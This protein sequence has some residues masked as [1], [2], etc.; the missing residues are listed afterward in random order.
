MN[1]SVYAMGESVR[2]KLEWTSSYSKLQVSV[3][4]KLLYSGKQVTALSKGGLQLTVGF[5]FPTTQ[6]LTQIESWAKLHVFLNAALT[7]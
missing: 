5:G 4:F 7:N 6:T 1:W 2:F 3:G